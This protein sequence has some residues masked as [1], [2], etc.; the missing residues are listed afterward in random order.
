MGQDALTVSG[1]VIPSASSGYNGNTIA[2]QFQNI[3]AYN[4]KMHDC[5]T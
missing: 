2:I 3:M 1:P 5:T 4:N